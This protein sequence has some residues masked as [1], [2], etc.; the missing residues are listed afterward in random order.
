MDKFFKGSSPWQLLGWFLQKAFEHEGFLR[1]QFAQFAIKYESWAQLLVT[2]ALHNE[3]LSAWAV[4]IIAKANRIQNN[5]NIPVPPILN[6]G[7]LS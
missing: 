1:A 4:S 7:G 6:I 3:H 2:L 5:F